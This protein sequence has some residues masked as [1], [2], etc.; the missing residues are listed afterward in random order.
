M[1]TRKYFLLITT[2]WIFFLPGKNHACTLWA[3]GKN[4]VKNKSTLIVKVRDYLPDNYQIIKVS[5][6][7]RGFPFVGLYSRGGIA[8]GLKAGV[9]KYGLVV[10][11][12]TASSIPRKTRLKFK[13]TRKVT[14]KLLRRCKTVGQALSLA[15]K[16]RGARFL[17]LA[18]S[19]H[20][21]YVEMPLK[22]KNKFVLKRNGYLYHT[23]HY[24][25]KDFYKWNYK[26][27]KSSNARYTRI[28][29]LLEQSKN[30]FTAKD[31]LNMAND[32][33]AGPDNS[34]FRAGSRPKKTRTLSVWIVEILPDRNFNIYLKMINPGDKP[35]YYFLDKKLFF[36]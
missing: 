15:M 6:S 2:V 8:P 33:S 34:I 13:R 26:Y 32:R 20:I 11:S 21:A 29:H 19:K 1:K 25:L 16:F 17:M 14:S 28:K 35:R 24:V 12:A 22:G 27:G 18:D 9:N 23:N 7:K 5:R 36:K 4:A 10:V 30:K 31:F 3:A